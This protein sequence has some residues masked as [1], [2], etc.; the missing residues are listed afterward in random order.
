MH[1][2]SILLASYYTVW[3]APISIKV[4]VRVK[5]IL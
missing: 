1:L 5:F 4:R 3:T 2:I